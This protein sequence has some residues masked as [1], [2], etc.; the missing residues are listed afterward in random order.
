M[1]CHGNHILLAKF[2]WSELLHNFQVMSMKLGTSYD[3]E[4]YQYTYMQVNVRNWPRHFYS[5][6]QNGT[7][8]VLILFSDISCVNL[9]RHHHYFCA[10]FYSKT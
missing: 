3:H 1:R 2:L 6:P 7:A 8:G 4:V 5:N 10:S 9:T